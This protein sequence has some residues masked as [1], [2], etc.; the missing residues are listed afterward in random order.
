M[1]TLS[2]SVASVA[3]AR[4]P[5]GALHAIVYRL[6]RSRSVASMLP[7]LLLSGVI[8]LAMT[9]VM[10][11]TW[12][13]WNRGFAGVWME[14]WLTTWPIAFPVAYLLG[15]TVRKVAAYISAPANRPQPRTEGL[16]FGDIA[17][18]SDSVT[19]NH[20]LT[21]L[22]RLQPAYDFRAV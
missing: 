18:A 14:S 17:Q 7:S 21:V 19:A 11:L 13:G 6:R 1:T 8:T 10:H 4:Q 5:S 3:H 2:H 20:G 12:G 9:A 22:R 15:P 16:V